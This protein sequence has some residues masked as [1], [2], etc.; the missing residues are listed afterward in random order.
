MGP[1]PPARAVAPKDSVCG[2]CGPLAEPG[3]VG[4]GS[5]TGPPAGLG[6]MVSGQAA[7]RRPDPG[8]GPQGPGVEILPAGREAGLGAGGRPPLPREVT[9][10]GEGPGRRPRCVAQGCVAVTMKGLGGGG[11]RGRLQA[12]F[13]WCVRPAGACVSEHRQIRRG[14]GSRSR[15]GEGRLVGGPPAAG[16]APAGLLPCGHPSSPAST[17]LRWWERHPWDS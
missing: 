11:R 6:P 8:G 3:E 16:T 4:R 12:P 13:P 17:Y 15:P 5:G 7:R 10:T 9:D 14:S 1:R 2:G